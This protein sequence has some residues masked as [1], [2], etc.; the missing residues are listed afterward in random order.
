MSN[1]ELFTE[2]EGF[3][4]SKYG[5]MAESMIELSE[6]FQDFFLNNNIE[7]EN[8]RKK[9]IKKLFAEYIDFM[10]LNDN[11]CPMLFQT[12]VDFCE[13]SKT[14]GIDI[15]FFQQHLVKNKEEIFDIW[16]CHDY[17]NPLGNM[18][19]GNNPFDDVDTDE[20]IENFDEYYEAMSFE[21]RKN[22]TE[23]SGK[24]DA[25][26]FLQKT[27]KLIKLGFEKSL[28]I[29]ENNPGLSNDECLA[30]IDKEFPNNYKK[31]FFPHNPNSEGMMR[32]IFSLPKEQVKKF[33]Q[34]TL[35]LG[36]IS[37]FDISSTKKRETIEGL[38]SNLQELIDNIK[39]T[40]IGNEQSKF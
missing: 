30:K 33:F 26:D 20:F 19:K 39:K 1:E 38:L 12:L 25:L 35:N 8:F 32:T 4:E 31:E 22:K 16:M 15:G 5:H 28:E 27:H 36:K 40:E 13:F 23:E 9:D 17:D 21:I 7:V 2:F 29:K 11:E 14:K 10:G 24:K 18:D 37:D 6:D 34:L 3:I